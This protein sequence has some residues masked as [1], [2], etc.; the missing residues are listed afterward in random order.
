M[1]SLKHRFP[2]YSKLMALYPPEYR[3]QYGEQMLQTLADMLDDPQ[4]SKAYT[5]LRTT[6]DLPYSLS[7]QNLMTIG[8]I[9]THETPRFIKL[10]NVAGVVLL[11]PFFTFLTLDAITAHSL[12]NK[13]VWNPWVAATWLIFMP[14]AA[15]VINSFAFLH[16][17]AGRRARVWT[18]LFDWRHNW[19]MLGIIVVS[20]GIIALVLGHD[21]VHCVTQNP[22][23]TLRNWHTTV[24][25]IQNR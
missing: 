14:A 2:R 8:A 10:S 3:N 15:F 1:D 18:S 7:K 21:S 4:Q 20:I 9:M 11:A 22:V 23:R 16:W 24:R 19:S 6:L 5:W 25:C 17:I 13:W 12:Y